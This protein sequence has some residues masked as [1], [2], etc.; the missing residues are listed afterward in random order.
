MI[1]RPSQAA[2]LAPII[3]GQRP[4]V[5][6]DLNEAEQT[7]WENLTYRLPAEWFVGATDP[8]LKQLV[9]HIHHADLLAGE[10]RRAEPELGTDAKRWAAFR[11]MSRAFGYQS[12]KI[13][14]LSTKLRLCPSSK[15]RAEHRTPMP[16]GRLPPWEDWGSPDQ[17]AERLRRRQSS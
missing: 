15:Y 6:D 9:R 14:M 17:R 10:I 8:L 7:I 11:A 5:P 16:H 2:T 12:D 13:A 4:P 3:P 1:S